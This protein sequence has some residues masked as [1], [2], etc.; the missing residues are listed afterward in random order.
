MGIYQAEEDC[1]ADVRIALFR[2]GR[3]EKYLMCRTKVI[4]S[5]VNGNVIMS[6]WG[7]KT[8]TIKEEKRLEGV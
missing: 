4:M 8:L 1:S 2:N 5:G 3:Q 7:M 6:G